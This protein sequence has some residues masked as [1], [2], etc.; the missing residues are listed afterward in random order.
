MSMSDVDVLGLLIYATELDGRHTPNE[1]KV[2]AWA[3]VFA[4]EAPGMTVEFA[5]EVVRK[6]YGQHDEMLTTGHLCRAWRE[7]QRYQREAYAASENDAADA[8]CFRA[9]CM[10]SHTDPCYRGWMDP[11]ENDRTVPC[12]ICRGDLA[13]VLAKVHPLGKRTPADGAMIRNRHKVAL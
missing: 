5:Q 1:V 13:E 11:P 7:D 4:A 10:C 3:D 12:P 6:H 9:G 2:R 8:S